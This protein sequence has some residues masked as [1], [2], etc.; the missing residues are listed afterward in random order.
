[1]FAQQYELANTQF[2][3]TLDELQTVID[4]ATHSPTPLHVVEKKV[5]RLVLELGR[6]AI[7]QLLA[8]LEPGDVGQQVKLP[9]GKSVK[10]LKNFHSREYVSVFG[11]FFIT[12]YVYGSRE[13]QKH[14]LIPFDL[15][16]SLPEHKFSYLLDDWDQML[17]TEHPFAKVSEFIERLLNL[18]QHVDSLEAMNRR[19]AKDVDAFRMSQSTPPADEEGEILVVTADGKGVP[20][21]RTADSPKIAAHEKKPGPKPG[22]KKIAILGAVY[23]INPYIRTPKQVVEELFRDPQQRA[24]NS[25][26]AGKTG[27]KR[28]SS[29]PRPCHKRVRACLTYENERG[30]TINGGPTIFGWMADEASARNQC[31]SKK[32]VCIMDGQESLWEWEHVFQGDEDIVEILDLLHVTPRVWEA[33]HI[34]HKPKSQQAK[35]FVRKRVLRILCGET[36]SVICGMRRLSS[37]RKLRGKKLASIKTICNYFETHEHRMRYDEYLAQGYPIASGVIEGAC[38]HVVK[39][40]LEGTGMSWVI[41]GANSMLDTRTISINDDWEE[42]VAFRIA[43]ETEQLYSNAPSF[44]ELDMTDF[45]D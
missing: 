22:R 12:R 30:E 17:A 29:R 44:D 32:M 14:A 25:K 6:Q 23:T 37:T 43:R 9:D 45:Y 19:M 4:D 10:R 28:D 35:E 20:M 3:Q 21:R 24:K 15:H 8:R 39:D 13:G 18:R 27:K 42:F 33:A 31:G 2:Q 16:L 26:N 34:F 7:A 36:K 40:R 5:W 41:E 1:M 11:P 38:R